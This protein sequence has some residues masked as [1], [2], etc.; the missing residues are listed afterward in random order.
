MPPSNGELDGADCTQEMIDDPFRRQKLQTSR[1]VGD[2]YIVLG[3]LKI[4]M[5]NLILRN[6]ETMPHR[7]L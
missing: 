4:K 3:T 2:V 5:K 7:H 6:L 1:R